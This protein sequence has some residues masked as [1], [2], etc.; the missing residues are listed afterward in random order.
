[1]NLSRPWFLLLLLMFIPMTWA[2]LHSYSALSPVRRRL[3][4]T[5]R[6]VIM[7]LL[8]LAA[9][10]LRWERTEEGKAI[11]FAMDQSHSVDETEISAGRAFLHEALA[12]LSPRDRTGVISFGADAVIERA[13]GEFERTLAPDAFGRE[14]TNIARALRLAASLAPEGFGARIVLMSDGRENEGDAV[15]MAER[16][17]QDGVEIDVVR[18]AARSGSDASIE[19]IDLP[20]TARFRQT[21]HAR[22]VLYSDEPQNMTIHVLRNHAR[23]ASYRFAHAGGGARLATVPLE[24]EEKGFLHYRFSIEADTDALVSN[25]TQDAYVHVTGP[26]SVLLVASSA[27]DAAPLAA[28]LAR[29]DFIVKTIAPDAMPLSLADLRPYDNVILANVEAFSLGGRVMTNLKNYVTEGGA[30][31]AMLGGPQSFGAGGYYRTPIEEALPVTMDIRSKQS[32]PVSALV[33]LIDKSGSMGMEMEGISK[34]DLAKKAAALSAELLSP[35]DQ[36]GV[37]CFDGAAKEVVKFGEVGDPMRVVDE[38]G[39]LQAGGGTNIY[40][41]LDMAAQWLNTLPAM[42]KH[43]I[44]LSDG[45]TAD[46]EF[47]R[48][49]REMHANGITISTVS[50]G[51]DA[52][53]ELMEMIAEVGGGHSYVTKEVADIPRI[54]TRETLV[55]SKNVVREEMFKPEAAGGH[56]ILQE[57]DAGALPALGGYVMTTA[58]SYAEVPL[59]AQE[60]DPLLAVGR[61]GLGKSL[62][63]TSD[64]SSRWA[65]GWMSWPGFG[66]FWSQA[67]RWTLPDE[68]TKNI[69]LVSE[70]RG[71]GLAVTA[72]IVGE[73]GSPENHLDLELRAVDPSG[74]MIAADLLQTGPGRYEGRFDPSV[75]GAHLVTIVNRSDRSPELLM[76]TALGY[77]YSPEYRALAEGGDVLSKLL[78]LPGVRAVKDPSNIARPLVKPKR[79]SQEI[80]QLLLFLAAI[81][82][83][84]DI[85]VRRVHFR[86]ADL[87]AWRDR[88]PETEASVE[89]RAVT[90]LKKARERVKDFRSGTAVP[91]P[92]VVAPPVDIA[93][94]TEEAPPEETPVES[95]TT[96][97]LAAK[98]RLREKDDKPEKG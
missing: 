25:N 68:T 87:L 69:R 85:A 37:I 73:N 46:G 60:G 13:P 17:I 61:S 89:I 11:L 3:S 75:V 58:K 14:Q 77:S 74:R 98:R 54:F 28:T 55:S 16:L 5:L 30:G 72:D 8:I 59:T 22:L 18:L 84:F 86:L 91:S 21:F 93:P 23:I 80:G 94:A 49:A 97:L 50:I 26:P 15:A 20:Q 36:I 66:T 27:A 82:F 52:N 2:W 44:L 92:Q 35:I 67:I 33:L 10:G 70:R 81:L 40:P 76:R 41:A 57:I 4:V 53:Q 95:H 24:P 12:S 1:M 48:L 43:V 45:V 9:A 79:R 38:I 32:M 31:L 64:A 39:S 71:N 63:W 7:L 96:R 90:R 34:I 19:E 65:G 47:E 42:N 88:R 78:Q 29:S 56:E 83:L 6:I 62:A 51:E